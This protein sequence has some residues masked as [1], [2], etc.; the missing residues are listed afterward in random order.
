MD[1]I[2]LSIFGAVLSLVNAIILANIKKNDKN[3]ATLV[4]DLLRLKEEVKLLQAGIVKEERFRLI[5][6]EEISTAF[7]DFELRLINE[8]R[9][10][11][12]R[13]TNDYAQKR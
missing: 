2:A 11:P 10:T 1:A 12:K 7:S 6:R 4:A 9:L 13:R 8:G 5:V 3:K